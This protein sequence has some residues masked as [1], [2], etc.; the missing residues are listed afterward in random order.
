M[1]GGHVHGL[2]SLLRKLM[3]CIKVYSFLSVD[4]SPSWAYGTSLLRFLDHTQ[5]GTHPQ[6][7]F[8]EEVISTSQRPL[9]KHHT[10]NTR[11]EEI[12]TIRRFEST[13]PADKQ[14]KAYTLDCTPTKIS[15]KLTLIMLIKILNLDLCHTSSVM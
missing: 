8:S 6:Y 9:P 10:T 13:T 4:D 11:D 14:L 5:L 12:Y 7:N 1:E 15:S 2:Y 3:L